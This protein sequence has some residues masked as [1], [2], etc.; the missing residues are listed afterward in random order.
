M[1]GT[2]HDA[3]SIVTRHTMPG[4]Y[5]RRGC[6]RFLDVDEAGWVAGGTRPVNVQQHR[7]S[8]PAQGAAPLHPVS[9]I[10]DTYRRLT[11][12]LVAEYGANQ[13]GPSDLNNA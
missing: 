6:D 10:E 7:V 3:S 4:S 1:P 9:G 2:F 11:V 5:R 8:A 13:R 12:R